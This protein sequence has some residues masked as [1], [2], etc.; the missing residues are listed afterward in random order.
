M[1]VPSVT[2]AGMDTA[3]DEDRWV[4]PTRWWGTALPIRGLGPAPRERVS[5]DAAA[6][7][8]R[9]YDDATEFVATALDNPDSD[10]ALVTHGRAAL[11]GAP[12]VLGHAVIATLVCATSD[13]PATGDLLDLWVTRFGV[14]GAAQ[15][16]A[17]M[18]QLGVAR[19][20]PSDGR[21]AYEGPPA[22]GAVAPDLIQG[23]IVTTRC[24]GGQVEGFRPWDP[25]IRLRRLVAALPDDDYT[26]LVEAFAQL[27]GRSRAVDAMI[28]YLLPSRQEW[29]DAA[30]AAI[31]PRN[32]WGDLD[33]YR[34]ALFG[35]ITTMDQLDALIDASIDAGHDR[36]HLIWMIGTGKAVLP[37]LV[38]HLGP[39]CA[40]LLAE[41]A[42]GNVSAANRYKIYDYLS[43]MPT[44]KAFA[45]LLDRLGR[46]NV[47]RS[48]LAAAD[49]FPRRAL[50]LFTERGLQ[51]LRDDHVRTHPELSPETSDTVVPADVPAGRVPALLASPPWVGYRR[52]KPVTVSVESSPTPVC[53]R[54]RAGERQRWTQTAP[55]YPIGPGSGWRAHIEADLRHPR[56]LRVETFSQAPVEMIRPYLHGAQ[57]G[58]VWRALP[59]LQRILGRFDTEAIGYVLAAVRSKPV[60]HI[61]A[62]LPV[63]GGEIAALMATWCTRRTTRAAAQQWL[64]RHAPTA[65]HDLIPAAVGT[66]GPPRAAAETALLYLHSIGW[67]DT[68]RS[69]AAGYGREA[70]EVIDTLLTTDPV[71]R[72]PA[73][74]PALP[75]WLRPELL[76]ALHAR[77]GDDALPL[78]AVTNL[79]LMAALCQ[80]DVV[81]AGI[82][83]VIGE[84][85]AP[86]LA[87]WARAVFE[88]WR[89]AG[90]PAAQGWILTLQALVGDD[91]TV[92]MLSPLIRSWPGQSAH[93]RAIAGLDAL[94]QIGTDTALLHLHAI[95]E[96]LKFPAL[97]TA[98]QDKIE[99]IAVDLGL[100]TDQ[101]G[102]RLVPTFDLDTPDALHLNYGP[103]SFTF[104]FDEHL[105]PILYDATGRVRKTLPKPAAVDDPD[106]APTAYARFTALRK[107]LKPVAG[108]QIARLE[109]AMVTRRRWTTIEF[110]D[111]FVDHPLLIHLVRRLVWGIYTPTG[112]QLRAAFRISDDDTFLDLDDIVVSAG[113]EE[114][115][116]L[117]HP[118][119]LGATL[120]AWRTR[121]E[122]AQPFEQLHRTVHQATG[123]DR[124]DL[125]LTRFERLHVPAAALIGLE[126]NGWVR[127]EPADA[128]MQISTSRTLPSGT[129][130]VSFSPGISVGAPT[131]F[132][133][134][135][136]VDISVNP[137]P[138]GHWHRVDTS[139]TL[140]DLTDL[141]TT[142]TPATT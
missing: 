26:A 44:D 15:L 129:V 104:D 106:L 9:T 18:T 113:D 89:H 136:L 101:L 107:N 65:A 105:R 100:T 38:C 131:M 54:W 128:G 32:H 103:R 135:Y 91:D 112:E 2:I 68:V 139:E 138:L 66:P 115:I 67:G 133:D 28:V 119:E 75:S 43:H 39:A 1:S 31:P 123:P 3:T 109:Q 42:D 69:A 125:R 114:V 97:K 27:R 46:K 130:T 22:I 70:A 74:M 50:R 117:V 108:D 49:R 5:A 140:R 80:P 21:P 99:Q 55:R 20:T 95:S 120:T 88:Q 121:F 48:V 52:P 85:D 77:G 124:T 141:A 57:P 78:D 19:S 51:R 76:P 47:E 81:Y 118:C 35:S 90:Y 98:A 16:V 17:S 58:F 45:L 94:A 137:R 8:A 134:Q 64:E 30:I 116:G 83:Q 34:Q 6:R 62:L 122:I 40:P 84:L 132:P 71:L 11:T 126:R 73:R 29:V 60:G 79:C 102:D 14:A 56:G 24:R 59:D 92:T 36:G 53:T 111:F 37:S 93:K 87:Q 96:K 7:A 23:P 82:E 61:E 12:N 142:H 72:L 4:V 127:E 41:I 25:H 86:T 13:F 33:G 63:E 110:T 10:P